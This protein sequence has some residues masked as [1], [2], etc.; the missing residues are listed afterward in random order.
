MYSLET[1]LRTYMADIIIGDNEDTNSQQPSPAGVLQA[2]KGSQEISQAPS[3]AQ[4]E[5][6]KFK[7][8]ISY[9]HLFKV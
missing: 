2:S 7:N 4:Q 5:V 1:L 6:S 8:W 3:N 9:I